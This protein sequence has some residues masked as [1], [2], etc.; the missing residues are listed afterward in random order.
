MDDLRADADQL[1]TEHPDEAEQIRDKFEQMEKV[2]NELREMLRQREEVL[3]EAG[4]LQKFVCDLDRFKVSFELFSL[5]RIVLFI[6]FI[7]RL[8]SQRHKLPSRLKTF[9]KHYLKP[10]NFFNNIKLSSPKSTTTRFVS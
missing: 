9:H 1:C 4:N 5:F 6:Y 7:S 10:R 3:G 2:W 8:D